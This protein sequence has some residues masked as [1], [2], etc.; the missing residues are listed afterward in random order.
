MAGRDPHPRTRLGA[1]RA[2]FVVGVVV[3]KSFGREAAPFILA[4]DE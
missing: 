4:A 1:G 3:K 2:R